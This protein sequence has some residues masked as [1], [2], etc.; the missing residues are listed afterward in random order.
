MFGRTA[1]ELTGAPVSEFTHPHDRERTQIAFDFA[2]K[3]V[4]SGRVEKRYLHKSGRTVWAVVS[5]AVV[6]DDDGRPSH[7]IS[8]IED[9]SAR[10][11]SEQALLEAYEADRA[12]TERLAQLERMRAEMASTV[13]HELRTPL[14]SAAGYVELLSEGDAGALNDDQQRML[15]VVAR[16]LTRLN[17]IVN[18]VLSI[19]D[20]DHS[21]AA[22]SI[23][24]ADAGQ[25]VRAAVESA[26]MQAAL[27]GQDLITTNEVDGVVVTGDPGRLERVFVNLLSNALKF[28]ENGSVR[29]TGWNDPAGDRICIAVVDTGVGISLENQRLI[30]EAFAQARRSSDAHRGTGLGLAISQRLASVLGGEIRLESALNKGSVFTLILPAET[31]LA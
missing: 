12:A 9:V 28:T 13:S 7:T 15:G 27:R 22:Q 3:D 23:A 29:I 30:F 10:R 26:A 18:D 6:E 14:T 4:R 24:T 2:V 25:V 5:Y 11:E 19:A 16:S 1:D 31:A 21:R 17:H 8:Q 20:S